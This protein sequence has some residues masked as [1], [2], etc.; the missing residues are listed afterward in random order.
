MSH[1]KAK[2]LAS[3][4]VTSLVSSWEGFAVPE[5]VLVS[6]VV[7]DSSSSPPWRCQLELQEVVGANF[8]KPLLA[9][10][11]IICRVSVPFDAV[12]IVWAIAEVPG[13]VVNFFEL[14]TLYFPSP[15]PWWLCSG[16]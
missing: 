14:P 8:R 13:G 12:P 5:L 15:H 6:V 16:G 11:A 3:N 2:A 1:V 9:S 10:S 4:A 7:V